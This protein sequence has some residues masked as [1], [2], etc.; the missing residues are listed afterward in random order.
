MFNASGKGSLSNLQQLFSIV[1]TLDDNLSIVSSSP[2]YIKYMADGGGNLLDLFTVHRPSRINKPEDLK[3]HEHDLC[4]LSAKNKQFAIR[5]QL[6]LL[7]QANDASCLFVGAPWFAWIQEEA[8]HIKLSI[9][10]FSKS[11]P[12]LDMLFLMSSNQQHINDLA[13][14]AKELEVARDEAI[15][16]KKNRSDFFAVMSHEMRT[17]LNGV[18]S[19]IGLL[20][21]SAKDSWQSTLLATANSSAKNLMAVINHVLDFSKLE[22][23]KLVL[24]SEEFNQKEL[25]QSVVDI[26]KAKAAE[27]S[28]Y[29]AFNID[30]STEHNSVGDVG[31]LRQV[32]INLVSNALKFTDR[33]SVMLNL[34]PY[35]VEPGLYRYCYEV[36]DTGIGV[37]EEDQS[38]LF[39]IFWS[40][41]SNSKTDASTGL[42]LNISQRMIDAMGGKLECE[43]AVGVGSTFSFD[44]T[45]KASVGEPDKHE[46][47]QAEETVNYHYEKRIL[48]VDDNSTNLLLGQLL[49]DK[50]GLNV[51]TA[52]NGVEALEQIE[53]HKLD[54]IL[55]D[56]SMPIMDGVEAT[57]KIKQNPQWKH[58]PVVALTAHAVDGDKARLLGQGLDDYLTKPIDRTALMR[59]LIKWIGG[60][61]Q[62]KEKKPM[63][64]E[65]GV[66]DTV[67][68]SKLRDEVG[69]EN[70]LLIINMFCED[71][72]TRAAAL[73]AAVSNQDV[74]QIAHHAHAIKGGGLSVGAAVLG[75]LMLDVEQ[76]AKEEQLD[77]ACGALSGYRAIVESTVKSL[78]TTLA[79][80]EFRA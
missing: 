14:F 77:K 59:V 42:G 74:S 56:I 28:V 52:T 75:A 62:V 5:G 22:A 58:I 35:E 34:K 3:A 7:D 61:L 55:M 65:Q 11:D 18:I 66:V 13:E 80:D 48:L 73:D 70:L 8:P 76:Y 4:L 69:M 63:I 17:P 10:D 32:L 79:E 60:D 16:A 2:T 19:A 31:K 26:C 57:E 51:I 54:I 33:G 39:D 36:Q 72:E 40:A 38:R 37:S 49:L 64:A 1:L 47:T 20:E 78:N 43:S 6:L 29:L 25:L 67:V 24:S 12:Q 45:L 41:S 50:Y 71:L 53:K 15:E 9:S 46:D 44:V 27:K 21:D 68:L 23:G 30:A